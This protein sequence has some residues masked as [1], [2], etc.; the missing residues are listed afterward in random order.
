MT[1]HREPSEFVRLHVAFK[2]TL[3]NHE[4]SFDL[5]EQRRWQSDSE[6]FT[7][8]ADVLTYSCIFCVRVTPTIE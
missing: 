7:L 6:T 3:S 1:G 4:N 8:V 5:D 2:H